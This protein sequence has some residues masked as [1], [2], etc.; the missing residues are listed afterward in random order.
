MSG[1]VSQP[2]SGG[3][4][5][6]QPAGDEL[7]AAEILWVQSGEAGVL[8]FPELA[9]APDATAGYAKLYALQSDSK[10]HYKR[11]NGKVYG[12]LRSIAVGPVPPADPDVDDLWVDTS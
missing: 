10:L 12:P 8:L 11:D 7:T 5:N 4:H 9:V 2:G 6:K 1:G 3:F